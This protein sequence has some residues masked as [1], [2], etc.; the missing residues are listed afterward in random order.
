MA[1]E[2]YSAPTVS[3][4]VRIARGVRACPLD[5]T[6]DLVAYLPPSYR[7]SRRRYPV[8]YL[9]DA[10]NLFDEATSNDGEWRVDETMESLA[11]EGLEWIVVGLP[12][13][14][15]QRADEYVPARHPRFGGGRAD[16]HVEFLLGT[17]KPLVD[18]TLRTR[19]GRAATALGGSS[20]GALISLYAFFARPRAFSRVLAMSL[21]LGWAGKELFETIRVSGHVPGRLWLDVGD[22]EV[23]G[24]RPRTRRYVTELEET[25]AL[26][27][28]QGYGED[29]LRVLVD[30]GAVHHEREWARRLPDAL[31]FLLR[32]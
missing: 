5:R 23:P 16:D 6:L 8:L 12:H 28:T 32:G 29:E 19:P 25:A 1:W 18:S 14:G 22:N 4:D 15:R 20:F 9:H 17:A 13:A 2:Q 31:R 26:L 10:Q 27:R 11:A 21:A 3:G 24:S 7:R 30:P